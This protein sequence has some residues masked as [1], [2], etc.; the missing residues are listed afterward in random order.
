MTFTIKALQ[1]KLGEKMYEYY[2]NMVLRLKVP[3]MKISEEA[4]AGAYRQV[5]ASIGTKEYEENIENLNDF[6]YK[7]FDLT[8]AEKNHVEFRYKTK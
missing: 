6:V 5:V 8:E 1:K 2:P 7:L 3:L 4:I